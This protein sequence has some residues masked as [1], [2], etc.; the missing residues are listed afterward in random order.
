MGRPETVKRLDSGASGKAERA[1]IQHSPLG[2][3]T[4]SI[5]RRCS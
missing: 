1:I 3:F 4:S 5:S 2:R